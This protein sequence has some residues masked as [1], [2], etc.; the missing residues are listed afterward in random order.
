[1]TKANNSFQNV[2]FCRN[3][4][5]RTIVTKSNKNLCK[6]AIIAVRER[7]NALETILTLRR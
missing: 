2:I 4:D 1:M 6:T 7:T 3:E 5:F